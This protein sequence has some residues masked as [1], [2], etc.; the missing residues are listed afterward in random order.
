MPATTSTIC[1][2][3]RRSR[4]VQETSAGLPFVPKP[5]LHICQTAWTRGTATNRRIGEWRGP[6]VKVS[7]VGLTCR[8]RRKNGGQ[9]EQPALL[10]LGGCVQQRGEDPAVGCGIA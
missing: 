5:T 6:T 4:S 10:A 3:A 8:T 1:I 2:S 9:G 7:R